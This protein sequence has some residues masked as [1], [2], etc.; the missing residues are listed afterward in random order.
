MSRYPK[1]VY[2]VP[3]TGIPEWT[4][5]AERILSEDRYEVRRAMYIAQIWI[6]RGGCP[7]AVETTVNLINLLRSYKKGHLDD[8][9][10]R[11]ALS[12]SLVRFVNET[13]DPHQQGVYAMP[14]SQLAKQ[15][16]LPRILVDI[17]HSATHD[18]LPTFEVLQFGV[19]LALDW[20]K[21]NYWD[22][23]R[24]WRQDLEE[25]ALRMLERYELGYPQCDPLGR[26]AEGLALKSLNEVP[27]I[28]CSS[29]IQRAFLQFLLDQEPG[30]P[31][32]TAFF[33]PIIRAIARENGN[34]ASILLSLLNEANGA[35]LD[36]RFVQFLSVAS[37]EIKSVKEVASCVKQCFLIKPQQARDLLPMVLESTGTLSL[38]DTLQALIRIIMIDD[39]K[40]KPDPVE[41]LI[42]R[43]E[44]FMLRQRQSQ[45][46]QQS[47]SDA[48]G[49]DDGT[50]R[51]VKER[52][53]MPLGMT[54]TFNTIS[55]FLLLYPGLE[56]L[57]DSSEDEPEGY[58][59]I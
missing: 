52:D 46:Q 49:D 14:I 26:T 45:Q 16:R 37:A 47:N 12:A 58:D 8:K 48:E 27:N 17:R 59:F 41:H 38:P 22:A 7:T 23:Q 34:L 1:D 51:P 31:T 56:D 9:N 25:D 29:D 44:E 30:K 42:Q 55:D 18:E 50:W 21:E 53:S 33:L 10:A 57:V 4:Y 13:V 19:K 20:L 54:S 40:V 3:W 24:N 28:L 11:L 36:Q 6:R 2:L 5:V 43:T 39:P 32:K 35:F 15:C